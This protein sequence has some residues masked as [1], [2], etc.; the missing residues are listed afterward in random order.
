MSGSLEDPSWA[1]LIELN[2]A[3]TYFPSYAQ[4]PTEYNRSNFKPVFMVE[5]NYEFEQPPFTDGGSAQNLR[6]QEYWTMLS[7][8][9]D[10]FMAVPTLGRFGR[11]GS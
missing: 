8:P 6:R 7:G 3:Y 1:P 10:S 4:V 9:P 5:A 2:A 11:N